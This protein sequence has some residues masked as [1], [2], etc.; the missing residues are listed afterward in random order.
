MPFDAGATTPS[1]QSSVTFD[2][3]EQ[4]L[5]EPA[6]LLTRLGK[7]ILPASFSKM[8]RLESGCW[9]LNPLN[10]LNDV[11]EKSEAQS[12]I[13]RRS[14][15]RYADCVAEE[16][17]SRV[18][19][20]LTGIGAGANVATS[21]D[22]FQT[23]RVQADVTWNN[24]LP[25]S[26]RFPWHD[27]PNPSYPMD[28]LMQGPISGGN[29]PSNQGYLL[30]LILTGAHHQT[31]DYL[32]GFSFGGE[33]VGDARQGGGHTGFGKFSLMLS[34]RGEWVLHERYDGAWKEVMRWT[35]LPSGDLTN[36]A[37]WLRI[38]PHWP[39]YIE[40]K[41]FTGPAGASLVAGTGRDGI[42]G[43]MAEFLAGSLSTSEL[44]PPTQELASGAAVYDCSG[45]R[46]EGAW[47]PGKGL[48]PITGQGGVA[49]AVRRDLRPYWQV[50]RLAYPSYNDT[51]SRVGTLTDRAFV[52]P[53][54]VAA[55]HTVRVRP[56]FYLAHREDGTALVD[57]SVTLQHADGSALTPNSE[58][59]QLNGQTF[60][61]NGWD[62]P[63]GQN[64]LRAVITMRNLEPTG[65]SWDTPVLE[66][67]SIVRNAHVQT[68]SPG[69]KTVAQ[70]RIEG[71]E[72]MGHGFDP[73][74]RSGTVVIEDLTNE[75]PTVRTRLSPVRIET[76][77]NPA[78][79]TRK[80]VLF[81]GYTG[82]VTSTLKGR[83]GKT[84]PSPEH[85]RMV[86]EMVG[87]WWRLS[88]K[89]W[90]QAFDFSNSV[91]HPDPNAKPAA[92]EAWKVTDIISYLLTLEGFSAD[93]L[94]IPSYGVRL[95]VP[96]NGSAR[97]LVTPQPGQDMAEYLKNLA[98]DYLGAWLVFDE[99]A[100]TK[101]MWRLRLPPTDTSTPLWNFTTTPVTTRGKLAHTHG[102]YA[103]KTSPMLKVQGIHS[104]QHFPTPPEANVVTVTSIR[105]S[106]DG[107]PR[108]IL[109]RSLVNFSS[110]DAPTHSVA[111]ANSPDWMPFIKAIEYV[112]HGLDSQEAVDFVARRIFN[113]ACRGRV[114]H[115]FRAELVLIDAA[116][117]EPTIYTDKL[118][119]PL[120]AGDLVTMNGTPCIV[121]SV[122]P[123]WHKDWHQVAHYELEEW[124]YDLVYL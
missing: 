4:V 3:S 94:D 11:A 20:E 21:G 56:V 37:I 1:R 87:K 74:E 49:I 31:A 10:D 13:M 69:A 40:F 108:K 25:N 117:L 61:D 44:G 7:E 27:L 85:R 98:R 121:H 5:T 112:D 62:T 77:Y 115:S 123:M 46:G 114:Y 76:T 36:S 103:A 29:H 90:Y 84:F 23:K 104:Y 78:F 100:G 102:A 80:C 93:Q 64:K 89:F 96:K 43:I 101:G 95:F 124:R 53:Y 82:R 63:G 73:Q 54:G 65:Q 99:N 38:L 33:L 2:Y 17:R 22:W 72:L 24:D 50:S 34:G 67:Y 32:F 57:A 16:P 97:E 92:R 83:N 59:Y 71:Y 58:S 109:Q 30:R 26:E 35:A 28:T 19:S 9:V 51:P 15:F 12:F 110:F 113:M 66:S 86:C 106:G 81:E 122:N 14:L 42:A 68:I 120:M 75:L 70:A 79:P 45:L 39:K 116:A 105:E 6:F 55:A 18:L 111:D 91:T 88:G 60:V 41:S 119:R 118:V 8:I 48:R 107:G 52:I 47:A